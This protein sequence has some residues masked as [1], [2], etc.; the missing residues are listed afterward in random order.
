GDRVFLPLVEVAKG[1]SAI[2]AKR[3]RVAAAEDCSCD[4]RR[5]EER[6]A[7]GFRVLEGRVRGR[8]QSAAFEDE[9]QQITALEV[10]ITKVVSLQDRNVSHLENVALGRV[11]PVIDAEAD[12]AHA[13]PTRRTE[14][15]H[16]SAFRRTR[17]RTPRTPAARTRRSAS[18]RGPRR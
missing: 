10:D 17:A 13:L 3:G 6:F 15:G 14:T 16:G 2:D 5:S 1:L 8:H 4:H 7:E 18:S 9:R 11:L 12:D